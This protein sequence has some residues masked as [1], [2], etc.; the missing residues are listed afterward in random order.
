MK[1]KLSR[2]AVLYNE[3]ADFDKIAKERINSKIFEVYPELENNKSNSLYSRLYNQYITGL[4]N[5]NEEYEALY[6]EILNQ[7]NPELSKTVKKQNDADKNRLKNKIENL[8]KQ[9]DGITIGPITTKIVGKTAELKFSYDPQLSTRLK[10]II[11]RF[12]NR[13]RNVGK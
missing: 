8:T 3:N 4:R 11:M 6:H 12:G 7:Y 2:F 1:P 5:E 10:K 9:Y 13:I